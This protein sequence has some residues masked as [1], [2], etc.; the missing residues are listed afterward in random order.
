MRGK[1][2]MFLVA[3]CLVPSL[4]LSQYSI[5][6]KNKVQ[7]RK[8]DYYYIQSDH[9]D[10]YFTEGGEY[11]ADFTADVAESALVSI[12]KDF[13]YQITNR[14]PIVVYA[15]HNDFQQTNVV[16]EYLEEGVGGVTELF[17]NRIVVPFD[18]SYG[19]FRHVIHHELVHAVI[20]DMFYGGSIQSIITNN[21]RLQLP[22]WFNEGIAEYES[23][24][25]DA[26]SDMYMRDATISNNLPPIDYLNGY[27]AYRGGQSVWWYI[28]N[29]YGEQK[30]GEILNRIRGTKSVEQGFKSAIGL[31]VKEL[32]E[33]W[34]KEQKVLYWPDIAKREDPT[35]FARRLTNHVKE[36][37]FYNLSPALSPQGDRI[38]FISDRNDYFDV[39]LMSALDGQIIGKLVSGQRTNDFEELHLLTPGISWSPD[40]KRIALSVKSGD[41]DAIFLID[42]DHGDREKL[43]FG[44][45]GIFSV[46]W[47]PLGDALAFVGLTGHQSDVYVYDLKS[48]T[49]K[50]LTDDVFSDVGIYFGKD[51]AWSPDGKTVYFVSDR[52]DYGTNRPL[53]DSGEE[54]VLLAGQVPNDFKMQGYDY[55]Q[56]DIFSV[57]VETSEMKR[58]TNDPGGSETSP[59]VSPD[60]TK[61]LFVSDRNG[62]SN[63]YERELATGKERPITNSLNGI[64]QISMSRDGN[65]LALSTM[66]ESG[67]DVFLMKTPFERNLNVVEI[68][69]TEYIKRYRAA[70]QSAPAP[71]KREPVMRSDSI[72]VVSTAHGQSDSTKLYGENVRIDFRSYVF[73]EKF[74][75]DT[76]TAARKRDVFRI[77]GN[78]DEH[79]NYRVSKYKLSFSPDIIYG[80]AGYSTF[81][82]VQGVTEMAFSDML[83]NHQIYFLTNLLLD[84]KNS[85]YALAYYYLASRTDIGIEVYHSA[86]FLYLNVDDP[87]FAYLYRFRQYGVN[88]YAS[89]PF[90]RFNR[91]DFGL[92]WFNLAR[93]NLDV[94]FAPAQHRTVI[95]PGI[96]LVHDNTLFGAIAPVNGS[97]YALT[98]S[99][100]RKLTDESL[101]FTTFTGDYRRYFRLGR[102]YV[103]A[104][105]VSGGASLGANA[106]TFIIGGTEG[107]I[108]RQFEGGVIP[109]N[110]AED[111]AFLT[112]IVPL[113][114]YNYNARAGTK[115]G[116][117]NL[118]MRYP[119]L[120][121][122]VAG[123]LPIAFQNITGVA[124]I[125]AGGAWTDNSSF[126]A[127]TRNAE[128]ERVPQDLLIGTGFGARVFLLYFLLRFDIAWQ[129]TYHGFSEPKYYFSLGLDF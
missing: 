47:S 107:W 79:G 114:G 102:D 61:L 26:N 39:F 121:Y 48:R 43:E 58:I 15:S 125:D 36:G 51:L 53:G 128:G 57:D 45:N 119:F 109:I 104:F 5:F 86:R 71:A 80:N 83:G 65:K 123:P 82:G 77:A 42:V 50:N 68:E 99:A 52:G 60:G 62:I 3:V 41:E 112:P 96:S 28:S 11:L 103:F 44:L 21:I 38:A 66:T 113:R 76:T 8:F 22:L 81:Y 1:L 118:E 70:G 101:S 91:L 25:W 98:L 55:N 19:Q 105:R 6:G 87:Y 129:Y 23:L 24:R 75:Q 64:Y 34:Q 122:L 127:S 30:I 14:I 27:F 29:K 17:K 46:E 117:V 35:S 120:K 110:S 37:N 74:G 92:S 7:Y 126:R 106:Q 73:A 95:M 85:D 124:F 100:S 108:N 93:D 89:R 31:S 20:N 10:V 69:P 54:S 90:D 56:L 9:F 33:R 4:A 40:G 67:F 49:L 2:V 84:L 63:I 32:S 16:Q 111:Y 18:G 78:V 72:S 94:P 115:Y 13:R 97:R 59:V 88:L 12:S 116:L